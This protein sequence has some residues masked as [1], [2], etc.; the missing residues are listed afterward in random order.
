[1]NTDKIRELTLWA[2]ELLSR[3]AEELLLQ[4][5]GLTTDGTFLP[6]N[7]IPALA[8]SE[9][10]LQ[11]RSDLEKLFNDEQDAGFTAEQACS[12]LVKEVAFTH[13]NRLVAL[14]MLEGRKLLPGT[15]NKYHDSNAFKKYLGSG[16]HDQDLK[17]YEAGST[18]VDDLSEGPRDKAYRHFLLSQYATL[19]SEIRVLFDAGNLPSRLF[20]RPKILRQLIDELNREDLKEAWEPGNEETIGWVYQ[21]FIAEEKDAA[22]DRV[23]KQK[24]KFQKDDIPAATQV[25]TPRWIVKFLVENSL[26]RLWLTMH[27]DSQLANRMEYLV[28]IPKTPAAKTEKRVADVKVLDPATGTMHFGLVAFDLLAEM[29]R[30]EIANA[31]RP[32]WPEHSSVEREGDIPAA[33]VGKNVHGIDIDLRAVQLSALT[34]YIRAKSLNRDCLIKDSNLASSDVAMFRG[35][36]LEQALSGVKLPQQIST[37]LMQDFCRAVD[38][39]A[40]MG[41]LVRLEEHFQGIAGP[42]IKRV[43]DSYA[44]KKASDESF[45][46]GETSKGLRL[47]QLLSQR[48]DVVFTNPPYMSSR[49]MNPE[50]VQFLK[51]EYPAS[52]GDLYAAFIQRCGELLNEDGRMAMVTQQSFMFISSYEKF[53]EWLLE[54]FAIEAMTHHGPRAFPEVQGE[55]VNTTAFILRRES[56]PNDR[57]NSIGVYF[58]LVKEP[59]AVAKQLAFE[60]AIGRRK[61]GEPDAL[62]YEYRQRDFAAISGAPWVYWITEKLR[63]VF[64]TS[65][66]L[67]QFAEPRQGL[68]T[69]DNFRFL[70]FWWEVKSSNIGFDCQDGEEC[71]RRV[72]RWYP[73]NKGGVFKKWFGNQDYVIN[74]GKNG[75]EIKAWADPLYGNSGWSRII[76][77]TEFYFRRGVTW[78]DLTGGHFSARLSPGGFIFDVSGSSAFP[79]DVYHVLGVMNSQFAQYALKLINPTVHVQVGD[80]ARL[81]M[82]QHASSKLQSLSE[83]TVSIAKQGSEDDET[84]YDFIAPHDWVNGIEQIKARR[85]QLKEIEERIDEEVYRLYEIGEEDRKAIEAELA[86]PAASGEEESNGDEEEEKAEAEILSKRELAFRWIS[87]A[88]GITLGRFQ[89]GI[90]GELGCGRFPVETAKRLRELS[91]ADGLM[92][93]EEGHPDDLAVRVPRILTEIYKDKEA[94]AII[95][96]ATGKAGALRGDL[97]KYLLGDFFKEHIRRYRKRPIYWLFQSPEKSYNVFA[98]YE[99]LTGDT[100]SLLR[101]NRY[102]GGRINR[103]TSDLQQAQQMEPKKTGKEKALLGRKI[104]E[105]AELLEDLKQFDKKLQEAANVEITGVDGKHKVVGWKPEFDDGVLLNAAPIHF[106]M[107]SWKPEPKK[108]WEELKAGEY[109]WAYTAMRYWPQRV[110]E[111]CK[112]NKSYAIAHGLDK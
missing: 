67:D 82:P 21:F 86:E 58:R 23:F 104:S 91:D 75:H 54:N 47:L 56:F 16:D 111:A 34:L 78:T 38:D 61:A 22:F 100:L 74:Y 52:K 8:R 20:P 32:G 109:D 81:P 13:L 7:Q 64:K 89:P 31:G 44:E 2:R 98:F 50:M 66:S 42:E 17:L 28:P 79:E 84:T 29:Y 103:A 4:V 68:A 30:E 72:E 46:L 105:L 33:I 55:K 59:D 94:T 107:P 3:E 41:S 96:T 53:R 85:G 90:E 112:K 35:Q 71:E 1:M 92:V 24:K 57:E 6:K 62:V 77:S 97:E 80:L 36:H 40:L 63:N 65:L 12:R 73:Y 18:P 106:L 39:G 15:I 48:Y 101:G 25:F 70:K 88:V 26:G 14:K 99:K 87:Y 76:K 49:N 11:T 19:A 110:I 9:E 60:N 37:K 102:L 10:A 43:V 108:A 95:Q 51:D 93:L 5:Y 83:Q 45:F 69:A 27:P